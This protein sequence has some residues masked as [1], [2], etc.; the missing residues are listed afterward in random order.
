[1]TEINK[2]RTQEYP[3]D[4]DKAAQLTDSLLDSICFRHHSGRVALQTGMLFLKRCGYSFNGDVLEESWP[5]GND[6][7]RIREWFGTVSTKVDT[8]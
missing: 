1:M 3:T 6:Y 7:K 5:Q 4:I 2:R 8:P